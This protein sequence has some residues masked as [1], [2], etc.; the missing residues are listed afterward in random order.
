M[1]AFSLERGLEKLRLAKS[2]LPPRQFNAPHRRVSP[3]SFVFA[4]VILTSGLSV[5]AGLAQFASFSLCVCPVQA[6]PGKIAPE[7]AQLW[8]SPSQGFT[9]AIDGIGKESRESSIAQLRAAADGGLSNTEKNMVNYALARLLSQG[10]ATDK[11]EA[12]E[13]F[14]DLSNFP[15]LKTQALWHCAE[16]AAATGE[17]ERLK[18]ILNTIIKA[19]E[20]ETQEIARATYELAQAHIRSGEFEK[21]NALLASLKQRFPST[22]YAKG[23]NYYLG[24]MALNRANKADGVDTEEL[25]SAVQYFRDYL[26]SSTGGR[27]SGEVADKLSAMGGLTASAATDANKLLRFPITADDL[28]LLGQVYFKR[29]DYARALAYW[30]KVG[31]DNRL[32]QRAQALGKL[33]K[34]EEALATLYEAIRKDPASTS[35]D[36]VTDAI[37]GPMSRKDTAEVWRKIVAL[38]PKHNDHA[39]WNLAVRSEDK[40]A[41]ALF[42]QLLAQYPTS[43]HAPESLWWIFWHQTKTIYPSKVKANQVKAQGL[44]QL[45]QSGASRYPR[46][47]SAAR[48]LFWSGKLH[49]KL[50]NIA[51]AKQVYAQA[52]N[53]YPTNYYGARARARLHVLNQSGKPGA[54]DRTWNT[55]A[56]QKGPTEWSWPAA[57]ELFNWDAAAREIGVKGAVLAAANQYDEALAF[58]DAHA[59]DAGLDTKAGKD[60]VSGFK[61]YIYLKQGQEIDAI[62]AAG[63]DLGEIPEN[64]PRWRMLYPWAFARRIAEEAS[65]DKVDPYLVHALI[66]EESRYYPRALSRS[67]AIG[68][69]QLLP[70]TAFGVAKRIGLPLSNKEE[71]FAPDTNIKLGTAYLSD[72]MGRFNGHAM[73]AVASYNGGP[74]AV[75]RWLNEHNTKGTGDLDLFVENIPYRETRDY[76]RKVFGSYWTYELM[77]PAQK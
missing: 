62:R 61:A 40:E 12:L 1:L 21:A 17:E 74:N 55:N 25:N 39:I 35:Y 3:A 30:Q 38:K 64:T 11:K 28:D 48:F 26:K 4:G 47:R 34:R 41:I 31:N 60:L 54:I 69:M 65:K 33:G 56:A 14:T 32:M 27:F 16:I 42:Q 9:Q 53:N 72:V 22:E 46:H 75:R 45:A 7:L 18:N 29:G 67:N 49:E 23:A 68:L 77:Y 58:I 59:S 6:A 37:T 20:A 63:R 5:S 15:I 52:N 70:G 36:E 2:K 13:I 51:A 44:A 8:K 10:T 24:Q 57:S 43:E 19:H 71:V 66:R 76:V 73:M 50:G